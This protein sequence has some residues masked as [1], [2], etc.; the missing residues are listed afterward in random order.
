MTAVNLFAFKA[1]EIEQ[2]STKIRKQFWNLLQAIKLDY[3]TDNCCQTADLF[4]A[5]QPK[6]F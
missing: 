4:W 5:R 2:S 3:Y 6:F 1:S